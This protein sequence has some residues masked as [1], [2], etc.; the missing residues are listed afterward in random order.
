MKKPSR[1]QIID[2]LV[3]AAVVA[4][5]VL[6][7]MSRYHSRPSGIPDKVEIYYQRTYPPAIVDSMVRS[8]EAEIAEMNYY[9]RT[10]QVDDDGFQLVGLYNTRLQRE[11]QLLKSQQQQQSGQEKHVRQAR[12]VLTTRH[13]AAKDRPL[14]AFCTSGSY[15][16]GGRHYL[17]KLHSGK[18]IQRDGQGRIVSALWDHDTIITAVRID[19][20]GIYQ[21]QMDTHFLARGQGIMDE[22]D[23]CHK[24]G[25]WLGDVQHGFG[26]DSSPQHQLRIGT[27]QY[28]RF[29]GERM[30]YTAQ[31]I[32]G[33][34]V[35]RHQHEKGRQRFAINWRNLR[36]TSFGGRHNING[37]TFP[38]SF[39]Y[40]KATEGT[41][42]RNRYFPSD[43]Q[44]AQ[45]QGIKVGAYHFFS[46][47]SSAAEQANYFLKFARIRPNDLPPV[48]DVEPTD[49]QIEQIGGA[50]VLMNRIRT[51]MQIVENKTGKRPILYVNQMFIK[52]HMQNA[53]DIKQRYNVWIA[54]YGE[55]KPDVKLVYWQ[56]CPDGRANGITGPVDVNVFNGFQGQYQEFL[57]TGF[58]Q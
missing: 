42:V 12:R 3:L 4:L 41:T 11:Y 49:K 27:Y 32:Y 25:F 28:G 44:Q 22:W 38:V 6:S 35:S 50:N 46:L 8:V 56:L 37:Q 47:K 18:A 45:R 43:Y 26:F 48:L 30:K 54:R 21:G 40:I 52:K 16:K 7:P 10:H 23:G 29:L 2:I 53:A 9:L 51:W 24:E 1:V 15:W 58:H 17:G 31:R 57:R 19:S 14:V 5:F 36:I 13:I 55:Y 20:I 39:A 33:I 34:D